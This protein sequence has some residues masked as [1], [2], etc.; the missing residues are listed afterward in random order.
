MSSEHGA[1]GVSHHE[2]LFEYAYTDLIRM[3]RQDLAALCTALQSRLAD[4][5]SR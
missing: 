2:A 4:A 5:E 3:P 1:Q